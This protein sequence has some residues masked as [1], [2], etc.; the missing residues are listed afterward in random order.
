MPSLDQCC[1]TDDWVTQQSTALD[2][3]AE[4]IE[5]CITNAEWQILAMVLASREAFI[6]ELFS[7]QHPARFRPELNRLAE[8]ILLQDSLFKTKVETQK[9]I[10]AQLQAQIENGRRAMKAYSQ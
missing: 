8:F 10:V 6:S 5:S 7:I 4:K 2:K 1:N 3:Y 9:Q